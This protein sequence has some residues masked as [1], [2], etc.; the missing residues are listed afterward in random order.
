MM[1]VCFLNIQVI[2]ELNS[3]I[4]DIDLDMTFQ[5]HIKVIMLEIA[6]APNW[7]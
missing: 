4:I 2:Y 6:V 1:P 5:G 7:D 3:D